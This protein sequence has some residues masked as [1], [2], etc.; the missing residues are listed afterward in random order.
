ME[1]LRLEKT[2]CQEYEIYQGKDLVAEVQMEDEYLGTVTIESDFRGKGYYR[3]I[4]TL[5]ISSGERDHLY[6]NNRNGNNDYIYE[7][8]VGKEL[9]CTDEILIELNSKG[10]L[11]FSLV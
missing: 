11:E 5:L 10:V 6:S 1:S 3:R 8:W 9:E 2:D 4:L 7:R